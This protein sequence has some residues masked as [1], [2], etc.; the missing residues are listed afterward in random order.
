MPELNFLYRQLVLKT[1]RFFYEVYAKLR[2]RRFRCETLAGEALF[3]CYVNSDMTVSC[4]CQDFDG[5]GQLGSLRH[6]TFEQLFTGNSAMRLRRD[7]ARGRLPLA[8]CAACFSMKIVRPGI[9]ENDLANFTMPKGVC[10][11]NTILC[12]L[13]C[14]SCCRLQVM[15]TRKQG[16][17]L[18]LPDVDSIGRTLQRLKAV[19]CGYYNLGEPFFSPE[20][21][22]ELEI[23]R[24]HNPEMEIFVSTNGILIDNADKMAAALIADHIVFSIDGVST[25]T[26]RRYQRGGDFDKAYAN[27]KELVSLRDSLKRKEPYIGWKYVVF[28]WNDKPAYIRTLLQLARQAGVDYVQLVYAR[29]P[30]YG[31]SWRFFSPFFRSIAKRQWRNR[32]VWFRKP[33]R[34]FTGLPPDADIICSDYHRQ[35]EQPVEKT[36][37]NRAAA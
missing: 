32:F 17:F 24:N 36:N 37:K 1:L 21:H 16:H 11:E 15:Q 25:E 20:I 13:R 33:G 26:V 29:T 23:L 30:W 18:T 10:V 4:N 22:R 7:L 9:A 31:V 5:A 6:A 34:N 14:R 12:N 28:R 27:M 8:R 19:F 2:G 3:G 35:E